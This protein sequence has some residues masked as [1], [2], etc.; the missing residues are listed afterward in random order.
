MYLRVQG[1]MFPETF[2]NWYMDDWIQNVYGP[3]EK[4]AF[5][6]IPSSLP[7]SVQPP[8]AENSPHPPRYPID[9]NGYEHISEDLILGC[10]LI[11]EYLNEKKFAAWHQWPCTVVVPRAVGEGSS[12]YL[13]ASTISLSDRPVFNKKGMHDSYSSSASWPVLR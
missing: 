13:E 10:Q 4:G 9:R 11:Q 7:H 3:L 2:F 1:Y 8:E 6:V 5:G 12:M